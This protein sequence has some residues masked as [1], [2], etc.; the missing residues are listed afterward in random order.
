VKR[1]GGPAG[2]AKCALERLGKPGF[3]KVTQLRGRPELWNSIQFLECRGE[4]VGETPDRSR[5]K[6]L[7]LRFEVQVVYGA[8]QVLGCL[9]FA[10][11]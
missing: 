2:T 10:L 7:V 8:R 9:Q 11:D 6:I 5:P 3:Q 1:S 4:S